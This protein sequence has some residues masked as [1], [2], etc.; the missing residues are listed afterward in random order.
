MT[1]KISY[2]ETDQE[3]VNLFRFLCLMALPT[4]IGRIDEKTA[5]LEVN[6]LCK[7]D[8][9]IQADIDGELVGALGLLRVKWWYGPDRFMTDRWF[10]IYP[11][12]RNRGVGA[13]LLAE[14]GTLGLQAGCPVIINGHMRKRNRGA[15]AGIHFTK[16]LVIH[17]ADV[18]TMDWNAAERRVLE[19]TAEKEASD[20]LRNGDHGSETD[21][22]EREQELLA[23]PEPAAGEPAAESEHLK[24][25]L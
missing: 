11:A 12:L 3:I 14:A 10:F 5:L 16:P 8:I 1:L 9:P 19:E 21:L 6:R 4:V 18:P 15:G 13:A 23:E 25:Q 24:H 17:P 22:S 7:E 2:T 20:V